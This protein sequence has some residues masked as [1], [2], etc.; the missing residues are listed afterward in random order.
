[1]T[2]VVLSDTTRRMGR[3]QI[4]EPGQEMTA[5]FASGTRERIM[6]VLQP[7]ESLAAFLRSAIDAELKRRERTR[8]SQT[9]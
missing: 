9:S 8:P 7:K 6:A 5:R 2:A 1:M 4:N 3:K